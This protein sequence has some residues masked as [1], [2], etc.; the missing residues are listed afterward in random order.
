MLT[1]FFAELNT[2]TGVLT[3]C[4]AGHEP[5]IVRHSGGQF[6]S[7]ATGGPMFVGM[8]SQIYHEGQVYLDEGD[9][10]VMVTDGITEARNAGYAEQFGAEGIAESVSINVDLSA[11]QIA[12]RLL[13]A[14]SSFVSEPLRDD[15]AIVVI[16]AMNKLELE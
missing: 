13:S 12:E 16:K 15:A 10:F 4:N 9:L 6:E 5:P 1:A 11:D 2:A 3:Y 8:G 7:L 14:A